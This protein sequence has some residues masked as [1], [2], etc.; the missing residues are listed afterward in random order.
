[1]SCP[2]TVLFRSI[3]YSSEALSI[4]R[5]GE[6]DKSTF[7]VLDLNCLN[8]IRLVIVDYIES[9]SAGAVVISIEPFRDLIADFGII[10]KYA[11]SDS[12]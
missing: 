9:L 3:F 1:M 12:I 10:G 5:A 8:C 6:I 2:T 11:F 7:L 4:S